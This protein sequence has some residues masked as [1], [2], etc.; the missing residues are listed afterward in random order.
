[1]RRQGSD[2]ACHPQSVSI[3]APAG[4][5]TVSGAVQTIPAGWF[6]STHPRGVRRQYVHFRT[7]ESFVSIHAPAG[8]ATKQVLGLQAVQQSFNPRTRGGCDGSTPSYMTRALGFN[9]RTRGGCD[10]VSTYTYIPTRCFNPRTR[11]GCDNPRYAW[12]T[13]RYSFNPRTRGGCDKRF[14]MPSHRET[15]FQS[16]HPRGVRLFVN[17]Q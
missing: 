7:S 12:G 14:F 6:Q 10:V 4:G 8:G 3:H 5:A 1:M 15:M 16:T 9:P 17:S 11:G 13:D 2:N